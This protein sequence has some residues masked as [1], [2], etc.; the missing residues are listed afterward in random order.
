[1]DDDGVGDEA[2]A[3]SPPPQV[4][5]AIREEL[6]DYVARRKTEIGTAEIA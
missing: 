3:L 4:D 5:D 2:E 6:V 1:M